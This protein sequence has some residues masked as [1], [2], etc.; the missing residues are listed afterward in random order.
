[1]H[2]KMADYYRAVIELSH[3]LVVTWIRTERFST[4]TAGWKR[5]PGTASLSIGSGLV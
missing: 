2:L 4:S 5:C 3:G 1:M